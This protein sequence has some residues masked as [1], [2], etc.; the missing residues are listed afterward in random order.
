[1]E[2][3]QKILKCP[4]LNEPKTLQM[5]NE[6]GNIKKQGFITRDQGIMI[7][8]WK[9][10]RPLQRYQSNSEKDFREISRLAFNTRNEKLKMHI[11][12]ALNGI[13]IPS[14]SAILM[15]YNPKR[16]PVIDIRVWTQL[17][18]AG[19]VRTNSKGRGFSLDEWETY[20]EIISII[21]G[22]TGLTPRQVDKRLYDIDKRERVG[23]LYK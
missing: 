10:P 9:S 5:F 3:I 17:Y 22:K 4:D 6:I 12:T 14:A 23:N 8:K 18:K 16:Y 21:A 19:L 7:L 1:M 20:L 11:L 2:I 13:N 15:V